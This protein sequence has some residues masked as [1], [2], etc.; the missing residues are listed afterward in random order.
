MSNNNNDRNSGNNNHSEEQEDLT[1]IREKI[2]KNKQKEKM[3]KGQIKEMVTHIHN[4]Y[5]EGSGKLADL[6]KKHG[7]E[8]DNFQG[9][10][11]QVATVASVEEPLNFPLISG[12]TFVNLLT[13]GFAYSYYRSTKQMR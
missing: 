12:L 11:A 2:Q 6:V 9:Q 3:V 1:P 13:A 4:H 5:N 8:L 10:E 7:V